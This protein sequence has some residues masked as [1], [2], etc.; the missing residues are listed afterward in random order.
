MRSLALL[1]V[2][3][4]MSS[5]SCG[6]PSRRAYV[7][8]PTAQGL[9][10][11]SAVRFG[12]IDIGRVRKLT[13]QRRGVVAEL[14]IQRPDAPIQINDRVAIRMIGLFGDHAVEVVPAPTESRALRDGDILRAAPPDS[15]AASREAL[16]RAIVH[17]FTERMLRTDTTAK[18]KQR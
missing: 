1:L 2:V 4:V 8:L 5:T 7:A 16:A 10:E 18:S 15:Q 13:L 3:L 11:G 17:E 9:T 12:G 6:R 14:L